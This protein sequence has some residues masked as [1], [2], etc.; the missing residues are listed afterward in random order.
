MI[1]KYNPD[2]LSMAQLCIL[3]M[4]SVQYEQNEQR[5][6]ML[7]GGE[8]TESF[9]KEMKRCLERYWSISSRKD[10][11]KE[12]DE[13]KRGGMRADFDKKRNYLSALSEDGQEEVL[14]RIDPLGTKSLEFKVIMTYDSILSHAGIAAWDYGRYIF[15]CRNGALLK[16]ITDDEA[17]NLMLE[18]A[19]V[20][21]RRFTG[22]YE[23]GL[24]YEVGKHFWKMDFRHEFIDERFEV[25][26]HLVFLKDSPW[27]KVPWNT[28]LKLE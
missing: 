26:R 17:W 19:K 22:W 1:N 24:S 18:T 28:E 7:Y 9:R 3:C 16:Y 23:Y 25:F 10:L 5:H 6:D 4:S 2:N 12:L 8:P 20:V 14:R 11:F 27:K 21:Q 13:L 15:L